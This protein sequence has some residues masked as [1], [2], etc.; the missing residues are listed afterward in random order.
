MVRPTD[1]E[2]IAIEKIVYYSEFPRER[3]HITPRGTKV[4]RRQR[5]RVSERNYGN[6]FIEVWKEGM[7]ETG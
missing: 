7:G 5:E 2:V 6:V 1:Q 3:G 4:S